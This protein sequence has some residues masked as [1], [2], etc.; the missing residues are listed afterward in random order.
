MF[1]KWTRCT[2]TNGRGNRFFAPAL[3]AACLGVC[4]A[5][6]AAADVILAT[7]PNPQAPPA[8]TTVLSVQTTSPPSITP[9]GTV[10]NQQLG[11]LTVQPGTG[12]VFAGS[13]QKGG[14]PGTLF[15]MNPT[16]GAATP[17]PNPTGSVGITALAFNAGGTIL[18]GAGGTVATGGPGTELITIDLST[19]V[20]TPVGLFGGGTMLAALALD[21]FSHKLY[22]GG[23]NGTLWTVDP[24]TG[25]ATFLMQLSGLVGSP[26][27]QL[28]TT[29]SMISGLTFDSGGN[30]F[31]SAV[32]PGVDSTFGQVD[33][34]SGTFTSFGTT[35]G[36]NVADI[37]VLPQESV[38]EPSTF[39]LLALGG[40]ALAGW[41]RWRK[42]QAA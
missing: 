12:A 26:G 31:A 11:A 16:N 34:G 6:R 19:G 13:G 42:R 38:P 9:I 21:P 22:G 8:N 39:A 15:S 27:H 33:L 40:G 1:V 32:A 35:A 7:A 28:V 25:L 17:F 24:T 36:F 29:S 41:R 20:G 30:L 37:A 2:T 18:Y 10:P 23:N 4:S 3:L 5:G 14:N